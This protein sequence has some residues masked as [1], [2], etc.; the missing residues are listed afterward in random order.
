MEENNEIFETRMCSQVGETILE[1][2]MSK[3]S[4][5]REEAKKYIDEKTKEILDLINA[6]E[7]SD[8]DEENIEMLHL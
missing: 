8:K 4:L 6:G 3:K 7:N 5:T 2:D 1:N